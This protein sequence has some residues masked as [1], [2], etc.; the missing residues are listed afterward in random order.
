MHEAGKR[1]PLLIGAIWKVLTSLFHYHIRVQT[2]ETQVCPIR[3]Y[4]LQLY[5]PSRAGGSTGLV[6]GEQ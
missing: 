1:N 3:S 4:H 5:V 6:Q 2:L